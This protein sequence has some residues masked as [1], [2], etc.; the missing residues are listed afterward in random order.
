MLASAAVMHHSLSQSV[1]VCVVGCS[2]SR[3]RLLS[4]IK[5][6]YNRTIAILSV[7]NRSLAILLTFPLI[8][9]TFLRPLLVRFFKQSF[10]CFSG[11][12]VLVIARFSLT[13]ALPSLPSL[14]PICECVSVSVSGRERTEQREREREM[15]TTGC[16]LVKRQNISRQRTGTQAAGQAGKEREE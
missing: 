15:G 12:K 3:R 4:I 10:S 7:F 9:S 2:S 5:S 6:K 11:T 13:P 8:S 14:S 1:C 16:S